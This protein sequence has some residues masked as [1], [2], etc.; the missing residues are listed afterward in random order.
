MNFMYLYNLD[1]AYRAKTEAIFENRVATYFDFFF[2][3]DDIFSQHYLFENLWRETLLMNY[4]LKDSRVMNV[5]SFGQLPG[6]VIYREIQEQQGITLRD[7]IEN[8]YNEWLKQDTL[9]SHGGHD[10]QMTF[11]GDGV[12][13]NI[14]VQD[15]DSREEQVVNQSD[16]KLRTGQ[17]EANSYLSR[18][19]SK[20]SSG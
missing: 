6:K 10:E 20:Q 18:D 5:V 2:V 13:N 7:Y 19:K 11:R 17:H 4:F 12:Q 16:K 3:N 9:Y 15:E 8:R 14:A 1:Y